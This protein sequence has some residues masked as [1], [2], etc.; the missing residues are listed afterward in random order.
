MTPWPCARLA[1]I[2]VI[3]VIVG[4]CAGSP[5]RGEVVSSATLAAFIGGG[6]LGDFITRGYSLGEPGIMLVGAVALQASL[7]SHTAALMAPTE[8]L[9]DSELFGQAKEILGDD[10]QPAFLLSMPQLLAAVESMG[11]TD[12]QIVSKMENRIRKYSRDAGAPVRI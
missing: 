1:R 12:A 4:A 2:A 8:T 3:S 11:E 6:G 9:A 7:K 10:M 5:T